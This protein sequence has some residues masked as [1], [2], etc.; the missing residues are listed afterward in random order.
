MNLSHLDPASHQ[1]AAPRRGSG[2]TGIPRAAAVTALRDFRDRR[3]A[4]SL[5]LRNG[6][7]AALPA[8]DGERLCRTL[9]H[10]AL[11]AGHVICEAGRQ[12]AHPYFPVTGIVALSQELAS[13]AMADV[14]VTGSEGVVGVALFLGGG[15]TS[16][17]AVV[18]AAS[19]GYRLCADAL[20]AEFDR[21]DALRQVLLRYAQVLLTQAVQ[22]AAC[23]GH[24]SVLQQVCR[25]LLSVR[26]RLPCDE[27]VLT[28]DA[29]GESLGV[30]RESI[31]AA[32]GRLQKDGLIRYGRGRITIVDR[33]G[34]ERRACE[35]YAVV[36]AE[37]G[38]L[39]QVHHAVRLESAASAHATVS[40][41]AR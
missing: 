36:K 3:S 8:A 22:T 20:A 34:L 11:P 18:R 25:L 35:C 7:L 15:T 17:R 30:R 23:R 12:Q 1:D 39:A 33:A 6:L 38:R 41:R 10:V 19:H 14:A 9:A 5:H 32:A 24:H 31:T 29:I 28:Q 13:G 26:D 16:T 27:L 40:R 37:S 4:S 21:C 2:T